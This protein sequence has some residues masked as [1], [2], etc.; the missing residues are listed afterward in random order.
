[1]KPNSSNILK[2]IDD[3]FDS[4]P[5]KNQKAWSL[6]NDFYHIILLKM[7]EL[8][9]SRSDLSKKLGKSRS[10]ITQMFNKTPN[11]TVK[12]MVEIADSI[13]VDLEIQEKHYVAK[14]DKKNIILA[15]FSTPD[16]T[17]CDSY[18]IAGNESTVDYKAY[19][20]ANTTAPI[21][22]MAANE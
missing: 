16:L 5:T 3:F 2:E 21:H 13:G 4:Y 18:E 22:K 20:T 8:N 6:I 17:Y 12:K 10:A 19:S 11:I 9:L 14:S 7:E 15:K 1:M